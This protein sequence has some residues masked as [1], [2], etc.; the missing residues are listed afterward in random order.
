MY[1]R[2]YF[3]AKDLSRVYK[4]A[5]ALEYGMVGVNT[6]ELLHLMKAAG[7]DVVGV[8]WRIPLGTARERLGAD[9]V[10][11]GNLD[12]AVCTASWPIVEA[13]TRAVLASN[14]GHPG[15]IFNLGHGVTP[16]LDPGILAQ[17]VDLVHE[18]G[19]ADGA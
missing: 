17:V 13:E 1:K 6:G 4:V 16:D 18:E 2:Q 5:E 14:A 10:L 7:A 19:R 11:Q 8:D 3:Y 9:T 15:H 12:P